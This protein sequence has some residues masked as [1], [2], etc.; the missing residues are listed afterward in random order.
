MPQQP[1][2]KSRDAKLRVAG[3]RAV[4]L[5]PAPGR[6]EIGPYGRRVRSRHLKHHWPLR[7]RAAKPARRQRAIRT[8]RIGVL[9]PR[10][11]SARPWRGWPPIAPRPRT[12]AC[13]FASNRRWSATSPSRAAARRPAR[14]TSN[15]SAFLRGNYDVVIEALDAVEPARTL[16]ARLLGRGTSVVTANKALVAEHGARSRSHRRRARRRVPLRSHRAVGGAVS[17]HAGRSSARVVGRSRARDRQRHLELPADVAR[18]ARRCRS[19]RRWRARRSWATRSPIP[20]RD[21]DGL[22]AADKLLL[23]TSLFGWGRLSRRSA[24]RQRHSRHDRRRSRGRAID[25]RHD[26][27]GGVGRARCGRRSRIRRTR[28][29]AVDRTAGVAW[30]AR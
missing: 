17:R 11:R 23:L 30:P 10:A 24:R 1:G 3:T 8:I 18:R 16:V 13:G 26:Q 27:G 19:R 28:V 25:R 12:R 14:L 9:G 4:V 15:P 20:S 22:D 5:T 21:L 2:R 6:G 7:V 29:P